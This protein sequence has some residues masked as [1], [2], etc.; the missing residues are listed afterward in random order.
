MWAI[1]VHK[2]KLIVI[3]IL[4]H[5]GIHMDTYYYKN[6][7]VESFYRTEYHNYVALLQNFGYFCFCISSCYIAFPIFN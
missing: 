4:D 7:K 2:K 6:V 5:V 3:Q 1:T